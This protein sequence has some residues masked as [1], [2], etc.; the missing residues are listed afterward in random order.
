MDV[1]R[2]KGEVLEKASRVL[3]EEERILLD[4]DIV[5]R[6]GEKRKIEVCLESLN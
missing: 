3:S 1:R 6:N 5:G 4:Q 2:P